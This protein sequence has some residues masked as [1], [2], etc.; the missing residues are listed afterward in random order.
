M[1]FLGRSLLAIFL[2]ALTAGLLAWAA[3]ITLS[4]VQERAARDAGGPP[5]AERVLAV[6]V[7]RAAE[8][9]AAPLLTTFGE[10][11]ARR[12]LEIRAP[13]GGRIVELAAGFEE[14]GRVAEGQV[15]VRIDPEQAEADL[16]V[17]RAD[18]AGAEAELREARRGLDLS[19]AELAGAE[20]QRDLQ[21]SSLARQRDLA[22]RGVGSDAQ[23]E[24]AE[25]ALSSADQTILTR[26]G[27]VD[28]A[29]A[30]IDSAELAIERARIA[31]SLAERDLDDRIL[32]AAFDGQ[33]GDVSVLMGGLVSPNEMLGTL[34]DPDALEVAFRLS[35]AQHARLL[36]GSG[37]LTGAPV[38]VV[39][40]VE[41][42]EI[43]AGGTV[44]REAASVGTGQTGRLV[45][46][47][48]DTARGLRP[49]DFVRVEVEEPTLADAI[50]LPARALS[51][52]DTVLVLGSDDRLVETP[53]TL[54]RR[55]GDDV[56]V[57]GD[58]AGQE[59]VA[60]RTPA[61]GSGIKVSP[62]RP[63]AALDATEPSVVTLAPE[64]RAR[65]RAIVEA[66]G[67]IPAAVKTRMLDQLEAETVPAA[68]IDRIEARTSG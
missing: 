39:L 37:D 52:R 10:I 2:F 1:R 35:A 45:F 7:V 16:A 29:Q 57:T 56:L 28:Q 53:V 48:L 50:R 4:A 36:D 21:A 47:T 55:Q 46:A 5:A 27:A 20:A 18:L 12:A 11:R 32:T 23:V 38:R 62:L 42:L 31:V 14:G 66:S 65:L 34:I 22:N 6:N 41:G 19:Q 67:R 59:V 60:E 63:Q 61:L 40:D 64:R 25:L 44:T 17:A 33:L 30:R 26:R 51:S 58:I 49:G 68:L 43:E 13:V 3:Q 15:L 8:E 54:L 24:T 9:A